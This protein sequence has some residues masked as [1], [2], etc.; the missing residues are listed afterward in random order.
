VDIA[1]AS[2]TRRPGFK[3]RQV[4]KVL[5]KHSCAVVHKMTQYALFVCREIKALAI[6]L[7]KSKFD[8]P[9]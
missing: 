1:Y 6:I 2:G 7:K 3:S 5:G 4:P 9:M 8:I